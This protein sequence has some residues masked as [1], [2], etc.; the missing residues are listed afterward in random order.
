[1]AGSEEGETR[2]THSLGNGDV[3]WE[4]QPLSW[5]SCKPVGTIQKGRGDIQGDIKDASEVLTCTLKC[6]HVNSRCGRGP[7]W[8]LQ[9]G[10][11]QLSPVQSAPSLGSTIQERGPMGS[12]SRADAGGQS[13]R[14]LM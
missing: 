9:G 6:G 8:K 1:M 7:A 3:G 14:C 13:R 12:W 11:A 4:R 5:Y 10:T 2:T